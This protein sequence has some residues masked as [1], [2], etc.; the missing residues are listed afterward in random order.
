MANYLRNRSEGPKVRNIP[1]MTGDFVKSLVQNTLLKKKG[2]PDAMITLLNYQ[3]K[4]PSFTT[5]QVKLTIQKLTDVKSSPRTQFDDQKT[6]MYKTSATDVGDSSMY[7]KVKGSPWFNRLPKRFRGQMPRKE[8]K[9]STNGQCKNLGQRHHFTLQRYEFST[10]IMFHFT[11]S[12]FLVASQ[13]SFF[14]RWR[15]Q[16]YHR[17]CR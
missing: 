3:A 8:S 1:A 10:A 12:M 13:N 11:E 14:L 15:H 17:Q 2:S 5:Q 16:L 9:G 7:I 4:K 6:I